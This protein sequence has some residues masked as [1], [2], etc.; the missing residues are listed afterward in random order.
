MNINFAEVLKIC[1]YIFLVLY[2]L[3]T[4]VLTCFWLC[5]TDIEDGNESSLK[6]DIEKNGLNVGQLLLLIV[7]CITIFPSLI[8]S[9]IFNTIFKIIKHFFNRIYKGIY[10]ILN[11]NVIKPKNVE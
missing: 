5:N 8:L 9:F 6:E 2:I 10:Y 3:L 4:T 1:L 7:T 11:I